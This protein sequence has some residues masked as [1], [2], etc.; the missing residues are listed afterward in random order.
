[1][2]NL[3]LPDNKDAISDID[4]AFTYKYKGLKHA[5]TDE[6]K[7]II[8]GL[9]DD[10][11]TRMGQGH[12]DLKGKGLRP[13][14]LSAIAD[15]YSEVQKNGRLKALR[16]M[17]FLNIK[18][19]PACG[20]LPADELDHYLPK[21]RYKVLAIYSSNIIPYCHTCNKRKLADEGADESS[22]FVHAYYDNLPKD[23]QFLIADAWIEGE[24]LQCRFSIEHVPGITDAMHKRLSNQIS[25]IGLDDR[26]IDELF[27]YLIPFDLEGIYK[28][29]SEEAVII[30]FEKTASRLQKSYG[31]NDWR[32]VVM[33]ALGK[34]REFCDG[35]F[36][37]CLTRIKV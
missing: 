12:E 34:C 25:R 35:G 9:Y 10:Y 30:F 16:D 11:E 3:D 21:S 32:P 15:S 14:L 1:M 2:W 8:S 26:V 29:G 28:D 4:T 6:E 7:A 18:R 27:D 17:L 5:V 36:S 31:L 24:G 33:Q 23:K 20:I 22:R 19:C 13:D 37:K